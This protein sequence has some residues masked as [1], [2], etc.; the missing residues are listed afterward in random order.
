MRSNH[1][2]VSKSLPKKVRNLIIT[3]SVMVN[4]IIKK[5]LSAAGSEKQSNGTVKSVATGRLL[6]SSLYNILQY[7][8]LY[9][10]MLHYTTSSVYN[11]VCNLMHCHCSASNKCIWN[12]AE[13]SCL[14]LRL[15]MNSVS[16][17][18]LGS[19]L[20]EYKHK[21]V[22]RDSVF[23]LCLVSSWIEAIQFKAVSPYC[24]WILL[25]TSR[26][27]LAAKTLPHL[28]QISSIII[29]FTDHYTIVQNWR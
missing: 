12:S 16:L 25:D 7:A 3:T 14:F 13:S 20:L 22:A 11:I 23:I 17:L 5:L 28:N 19:F 8:T 26:W 4:P 21:Q 15:A 2:F 27:Q 24:A 29:Q 10:I 6:F 18:C 1:C 9:C